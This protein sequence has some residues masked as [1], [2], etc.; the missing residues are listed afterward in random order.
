M[1]LSKIS[2]TGNISCSV[3]EVSGNFYKHPTKKS[4]VRHNTQPILYVNNRPV[5]SSRRYDLINQLLFNRKSSLFLTVIGN[6]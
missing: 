5:S 2:E 1:G 6:I 4:Q 3:V